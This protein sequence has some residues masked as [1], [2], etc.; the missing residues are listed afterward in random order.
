MTSSFSPHFHEK[1][2]LTVRTPAVAVLQTATTFFNAILGLR[3]RLWLVRT[4][5]AFEQPF[6]QNAPNPQLGPVLK[7]DRLLG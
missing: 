1:C 2:R 3:P 6:D 7:S 5:G 4:F